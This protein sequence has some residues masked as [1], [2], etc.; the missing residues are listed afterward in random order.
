MW[1]W[2]SAGDRPTVLLLHGWTSTAALNWSPTMLALAR[3]WRVVAPD[4][5]G[6]GRGIRGRRFTLEDC[7]DDLA[8]LVRTLDTAPVIVV[9]YS[10]GGPIAQ[11]LWRRH[12]DVV[13]GMVLCATG[14][15]L[16]GR[17]D[18]APA[19]T[20]VGMGLSYLISAI[21]GGWHQQALTRM[22]EARD[23]N[24]DRARW[25][26]SEQGR[27]DPALLVQAAAALNNYD[28]T[29]WIGEIDV[30]TTV[31]ITTKDRTVPPDRQWQLAR[32]IPDAEHAT[33]AWGHRACV[34]AA[35]RFVPALDRACHST[36]GRAHGIGRTG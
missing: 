23:D 36:W 24:P 35:D 2:D 25:V 22:V 28:A 31:I 5:R 6:H 7:A 19:V 12:P 14:A 29:P 30:P 10:M 16:P 34:E 11:L 8:G 20:A 33:I 3:S 27:S 1:V 17:A 4:L 21:P 18:L 15:R 13:A 26:I 9:G 32:T